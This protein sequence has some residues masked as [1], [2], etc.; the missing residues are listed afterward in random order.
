MGEITTNSTHKRA[1][2]VIKGPKGA[3]GLLVK[4]WDPVSGKQMKKSAF[5]GADWG[6]LPRGLDHFD[7][8]PVGVA[9]IT[10]VEEDMEFGSESNPLEL[11]FGWPKDKEVNFVAWMVE[12]ETEWYEVTATTAQTPV[13]SIPIHCPKTW[14][15]VAP[16]I[17]AF[18]PVIVL[19]LCGL[20]LKLMPGSGL[21][22]LMNHTVPMGSFSVPKDYFS[23]EIGNPWYIV[24][25]LTFDILPVTFDLSVGE[26]LSAVVFYGCQIASIV[27]IATTINDRAKTDGV[28]DLHDIPGPY[29]VPAARAIGRNLQ[30]SFAMVLLLPTRKSIWPALIGISFERCIKYHR[31][32]SR[33]TFFMMILHFVLM[34]GVY[35]MVDS[36]TT[37]D[38]CHGSY[39]NLYGTLA[40]I[41]LVILIFFSLEPVRRKMYELFYYTHFLWIGVIALGCMHS[42]EMIY[43]VAAPIALWV[44]DR[45]LRCVDWIGTAKV[46]HAVAFEGDVAKLVVQCP[47]IARA[48]DR[49]GSRAIGSYVYVKCYDA[50]GNPVDLH[51]FSISGFP[52]GSKNMMMQASNVVTVPFS[53]QATDALAPYAPPAI[54]PSQGPTPGYYYPAQPAEVSM[55]AVPDLEA[56]GGGEDSTVAGDDAITLHIKKMGD[57][58][59]SSALVEAVRGK[60]SDLRI[61]LEGPYGYMG[62]SLEHYSTVVCV[63]GGIGFTPMA[64]LLEMA[65]N[66]DKCNKLLPKLLRVWVVWTVQKKEHVAWFKALLAQCAQFNGRVQFKVRV[67]VTRDSPPEGAVPCFK[68]RA[69]MSQ[70]MEEVKQEDAP[71]QIA[72]LACGP[73]AMV[74]ET[75]SLGRASGMHCHFETFLL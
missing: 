9:A 47:K 34:L 15:S 18:A 64:P 63:G 56:K 21:D 69:D 30:Y 45:L 71:G 8:C 40:F 7:A 37:R 16:V 65:L 60:G 22:T 3:E 44:I 67:H 46:Q 62:V 55:A 61:T 73:A 6:P 43:Y 27:L 53:P 11:T 12:E 39:G 58:T 2:V 1:T 49:L 66:E 19:I 38:A 52:G 33:W 51:P 50:S 24:R 25:L 72:V 75:M 42:T 28:A 5:E 57:K 17:V 74:K 13:G 41:L 26:T 36:F 35:G 10:H 23:E 14:I 59:W 29:D 20:L 54:A 32:I 68:G 31:M 48:I 4:A 70:V